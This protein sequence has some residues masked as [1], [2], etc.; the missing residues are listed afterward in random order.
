MVPRRQ[1]QMS[2]GQVLLFGVAVPKLEDLMDPQLR[3]IDVALE[4]PALVDAVVAAMRQRFPESK[5]RGRPGTPAEVAL[6][7]LVLKHLR[8]WS[9]EQLEWEVAGNLVY[10]HFCR[11]HAGKV[12]DAKTMVRLGL[13]LDGA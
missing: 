12:P 13:L 3:R 7:L 2:L 5:R 8:S 9:Y 1:A 4:D 10:R 6:R 11:I